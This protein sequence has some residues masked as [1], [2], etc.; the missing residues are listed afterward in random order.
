MAPPTREGK[1]NHRA[2]F[3]P[4]SID[5]NAVP[6]RTRQK[7]QPRMRFLFRQYERYSR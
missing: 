4:A 7:P 1:G 5:A 3:A 6:D 2:E